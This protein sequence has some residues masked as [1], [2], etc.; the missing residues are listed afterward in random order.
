MRRLLPARMDN[1]S[2]SMSNTI[3]AAAEDRTNAVASPA[4]SATRRRL[5]RIL[6]LDDFER[7][8]E[9]F[10]PKR[11]F[12]F[13]ASGAEDCAAMR[14]NRAAY[15]EFSFVTRVMRDVSQRSQQVELF[16]ERYTSPF[17][18][19]PLGLC[20]LSAYRGDLV[21]ARAAG[22]ARIP[23]ILSGSSLIP[24]EAV[25][26]EGTG[27]WFQAYLPGDEARTVALVQRVAKAGFRTLVLTLDTPV[28]ANR[29]NNTRAGF[30]IPLRPDA[31][32][33]WDGVT[34]PR[35]LLGTFLQ[36]LWRHGMPHFENSYATRGVPILS[37]D[38]VRSYAERG[39]LHWAHFDLVRRMWNGPLVVKGVLSKADA[40]EAR[41]RGADGAIVS[42]H[43]GRQLDAAVAP[44]RVL[45]GIVQACP[46]WPV[47]VDGGIRR[48]T[49]VLKALALGAR[50]VF[51]GRPFNFAA[52][53][54]G[55]E[56]VRHAIALLRDE[57]DRNMGLLGLTDLSMLTREHL[58]RNASP[59]GEV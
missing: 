59:T 36:T 50:M 42:N 33:A 3:P 55:E 26:A 35:W 56:G 43:G 19:A 48:G 28:S 32:L 57:V 58:F 29:E 9:A 23:M 8:A 1:N 46:G 16:G 40:I 41:D 30:T 4:R 5:D 44:L 7:A 31:S 27:A 10:L 12:T 52:A 14:G 15:A 47:M 20:A 24:M 49:D 21:L 18:I 53:I 25:A 34:H 11:V 39:H 38:V 17:G 51:L 54:A 37:P 6:N 2:C 22:E 13:V 45:P